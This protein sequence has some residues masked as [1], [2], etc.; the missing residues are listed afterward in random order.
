V[1]G[2]IESFGVG[3]PFGVGVFLGALDP[4]NIPLTIAAAASIAASGISGASRQWSS[5]LTR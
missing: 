5:S 3:K 2:A 1:V 4:K